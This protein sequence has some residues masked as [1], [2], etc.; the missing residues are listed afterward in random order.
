VTADAETTFCT[1]ANLNPAAPGQTDS[2]DAEMDAQ[3]A[4]IVAVPRTT[5]RVDDGGHRRRADRS[6]SRSRPR[7]GALGLAASAFLAV[8]ASLLWVSPSAGA[9]SGRAAAVAPARADLAHVPTMAPARHL[10]P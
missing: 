1:L 9:P 7:Y 5:R 4:R 10:M 6:W 8:V 2:A 3:I